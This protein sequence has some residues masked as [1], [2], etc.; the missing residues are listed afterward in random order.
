[1]LSEK[2]NQK[3]QIPITSPLAAK[4]LADYCAWQIP[5]RT[6]KSLFCPCVCCLIACCGS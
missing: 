2:S 5:S 1:M 4:A 3:D 6:G